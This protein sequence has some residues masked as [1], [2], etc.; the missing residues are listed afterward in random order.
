[1]QNN[2]KH[3]HTYIFYIYIYI[4]IKLNHSAV[5]LKP[6]INKSNVVQL[7]RRNCYEDHLHFIFWQVWLPYR[8]SPWSRAH[9]PQEAPPEVFRKAQRLAGGWI[10]K[11]MDWRPCG[12]GQR[13]KVSQRGVA[14]EEAIAEVP[15]ADRRRLLGGLRREQSKAVVHAGAPHFLHGQCG[16]R[17]LRKADRCVEGALIGHHEAHHG[18]RQQARFQTAVPG[19]L[20]YSAY[21]GSPQC[22]LPAQP[23]S[24]SLVGPS[25]NGPR[26]KSQL[27]PSLAGYLRQV[28]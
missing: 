12:A 10:D 13:G 4:Y 1:M 15:V 14:K 17:D 22:C 9:Q 16:H 27:C 8:R 3:I 20:Y 28:T 23:L 2:M 24:F 6:N 25:F 11:D 19:K 26:I 7:N 21:S 18:G 5:H